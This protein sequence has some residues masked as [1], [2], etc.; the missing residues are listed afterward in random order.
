MITWADRYGATFGK[1]AHLPAS[2]FVE[3]KTLHYVPFVINTTTPKTVL[4]DDAPYESA[5]PYMGC[6]RLYF[7]VIMLTGDVSPKE[8]GLQIPPG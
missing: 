1:T 4:T 6:C 3:E 8:T 7:S 5:L 2:V